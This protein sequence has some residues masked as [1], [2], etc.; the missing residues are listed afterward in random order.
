MGTVLTGVA[1]A[2][3]HGVNIPTTS[4]ANCKLP[5]RFAVAQHCRVFLLHRYER[6]NVGEQ[7]G[8]K[9]VAQASIQQYPVILLPLEACS[10]RF[11]SDKWA[12]AEDPGGIH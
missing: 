1:F 4:I 12:P 10:L 6:W 2:L 11:A 3:L 5:T 7:Q 8:H 9:C